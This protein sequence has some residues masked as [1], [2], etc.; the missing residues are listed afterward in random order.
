MQ[1]LCHVGDV[2]SKQ[3]SIWHLFLLI[4]YIIIRVIIF[5]TGSLFPEI[6]NTFL[7]VTNKHKVFVYSKSVLTSFFL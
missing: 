6:Y 2:K 1:L 4:Y 3:K 7:K 5:C